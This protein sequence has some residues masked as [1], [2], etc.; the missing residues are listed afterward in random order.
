MGRNNIFEKFVSLIGVLSI[1]AIISIISYWGYD[2]YYKP[3]LQ[4]SMDMAKLNEAIERIP[5]ANKTEAFGI[6]IT[7]FDVSIKDYLKSANFAKHEV[8]DFTYGESTR[9]GA[10]FIVKYGEKEAVKVM[11]LNNDIA[12][13]IA[14]DNKVTR[15]EEGE[16]TFVHSPDNR[17]F[18]IMIKLE[19]AKALSLHTIIK[20]LSSEPANP[21]ITSLLNSKINSLLSQ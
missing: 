3:E 14:T 6:V 15:D 17:E 13:E 21:E 11:I 2:T 18:A 4:I 9:K 8:Y 20:N 5:D 1:I 10:E 16:L 19:N 7:N 12:F